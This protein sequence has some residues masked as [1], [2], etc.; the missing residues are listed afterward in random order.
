MVDP[1]HRVSVSVHS[2]TNL[3]PRKARRQTRARR[4]DPGSE[5][6]P[7]LAGGAA[8]VS[9]GGPGSGRVATGWVAAGSAAAAR[10][11]VASMPAGGAG[12][13]RGGPGSGGV[14]AG[15]VVQG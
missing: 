10:C 4:R 1:A 2:G 5:V 7:M 13:S 14:D 12:A 9:R 3:R 6:G 15:W 11:Q 8:G